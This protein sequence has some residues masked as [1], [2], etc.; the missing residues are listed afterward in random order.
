MDDQVDDSGGADALLT[1]TSADS[2]GVGAKSACFC[3]GASRPVMLD[4]RKH[5]L[6]LA[7]LTFQSSVSHHCSMLNTIFF[8]LEGCNVPLGSNRWMDIGF[9]GSNP[10]TDIRGTGMLGVLQVRIFF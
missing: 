4:D 2:V 10:S 5:F 7:K 3:F 6:S 9:Q 1:T 8:A